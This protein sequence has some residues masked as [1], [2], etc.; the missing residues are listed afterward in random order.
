MATHGIPIRPVYIDSMFKTRDRASNSGF[1]YELVESV[2]L[3]DKRCCVLMMSSIKQQHVSGNST[4][5]TNS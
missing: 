3:A 1:K 4:P 2:E 5:S